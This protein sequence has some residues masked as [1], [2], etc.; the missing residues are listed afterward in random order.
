M[1]KKC[2]ICNKNKFKIVWNNKIR[3][4]KNKFTKKKE[5]VYQCLNCNIVFLKNRRKKLEN[6]FIARTIYNKNSSI[7][8]FLKFHK[9]RELKKLEICRKFINFKNKNILESNCG[10]GTLLKKLKKEAKT[11]S[12]IDNLYYKYYLEQN[13]HNYFSSLDNAIDKKKSF[14]IIFSL[15]ELEHKY[16]PLQFLKKIKKLLSK[17]GRLILRIPNHKNIYA[18]LLGKYFYKYDFRTS[19]NYYFSEK[20][21]NILLKKAGFEIQNKLGFHEYEFNHLLAYIKSRKRIT[22]TYKSLI[23][24]K[25]EIILKNNIESSLTSTSLVYIIK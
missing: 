6:S 9:P 2:L 20:N 19:H 8:E 1:I 13:G 4:G 23:R 12:G 15:S 24:K 11:T 21:I 7:K 18:I 10:A 3:S 14:D 17:K 22:G 25:D 16:N 5:I